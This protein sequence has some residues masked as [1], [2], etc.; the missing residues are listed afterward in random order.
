M[1]L[2]GIPTAI[3]WSGAGVAMFA[4]RFVDDG[5]ERLQAIAESGRAALAS[6]ESA[7]RKR[8]S[9]RRIA[10]SSATPIVLSAPASAA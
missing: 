3:V 10:G 4:R 7:D 2:H 6:G 5:I 9:Q 1:E 8:S